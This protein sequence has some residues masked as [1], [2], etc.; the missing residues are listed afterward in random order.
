MVGEETTRPPK[1]ISLSFWKPSKVFC[2]VLYDNQANW[3]QTCVTVLSH[4]TKSERGIIHL[5]LNSLN[6]I[7]IK[8]ALILTF[9]AT[10]IFKGTIQLIPILVFFF[11]KEIKRN[12]WQITKLD[13]YYVILRPD[14]QTIRTGFPRCSTWKTQVIRICFW[15]LI[16]GLDGDAPCYLLGDLPVTYSVYTAY[17]TF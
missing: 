10:L 1:E 2:S 12:K 9:M 13:Y 11:L 14:E 15:K 7:S 5:T 3:D 8:D 6:D 16:C 17:T 4:P